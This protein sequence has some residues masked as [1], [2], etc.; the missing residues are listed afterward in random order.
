MEH[1]SKCHS[2]KGKFMEIEN[3]WRFRDPEGMDRRMEQLHASVGTA[4][5]AS[6]PASQDPAKASSVARVENPRALLGLPPAQFR[7]FVQE[8]QTR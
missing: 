4:P 3:S 1:V 7:V 5:A 2:I 8:A 6:S